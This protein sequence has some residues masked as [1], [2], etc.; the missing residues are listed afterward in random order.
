MYIEAFIVQY[1]LIS[2]FPLI[3]IRVAAKVGEDNG[4]GDRP[5]CE[6]CNTKNEIPTQCNCRREAYSRD[7]SMRRHEA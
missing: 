2:R 6:E 7:D 4:D 1:P 3:Q 5:P